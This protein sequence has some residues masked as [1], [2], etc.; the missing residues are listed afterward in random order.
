MKDDGIDQLC[1]RVDTLDK[2]N[3]RLDLGVVVQ[4]T[5]LGNVE[6][7]RRVG[8]L[9]CLKGQFDILLWFWFKKGNKHIPKK[10]T[11]PKLS[12]QIDDRSVPSA[13]NG[14]LKNVRKWNG[15]VNAHL[16]NHNPL[17][18]PRRLVLYLEQTKKGGLTYSQLKPISL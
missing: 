14:F 4:E 1:G 13:F 12:A 16:L 8:G 15:E 6:Q 10:R 5:F 18:S 9:G 2:L 17:V 3:K 11:S 7:R